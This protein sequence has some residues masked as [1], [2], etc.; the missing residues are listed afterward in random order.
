[1]TTII[2]LYAGPGSGKSTTAAKVFAALKDIGASVELVQ[3]EA[4]RYAWRGDAIG[5]TEQLDIFL[6][7]G[8]R[9]SELVGKVDYVVTDSPLEL[10]A[11]YARQ[12]SA[13]AVADA[14][15]LLVH[16]ARKTQREHG[17]MFRDY[18][19]ERAKPYDPRGRYQDEMTAR[20][21]DT[22]ILDFMVNEFGHAP[23][24]YGADH[25]VYDA[26]SIVR[27]AQKAVAV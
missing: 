26:V 10:C 20:D 1:M 25:V 11:F 14:V 27:S 16:H 4:K 23:L 12:F 13:H 15:T 18:A 21:F 2:N 22:K 7:Q 3:E 6:A 9:E 5:D 8:R 17:V 19:I 24:I